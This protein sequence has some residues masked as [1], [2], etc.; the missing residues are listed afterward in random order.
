MFSTV[1]CTNEKLMQVVG[2][3]RRASWVAIDT[4]A[5]SL[6][7]YPEKL[8]L[9]QVCTEFGARLIDPLNGVPLDEL[10]AALSRHELIL[11]GGDYDL[12][13]LYKHAKFV[14]SRVFDT[15][16]AARLLGHRKFG[17]VHLLEQYLGITLE[18][19]PQKAN[20]A[21][22]P[23]TERMERYAL[24]DVQYLRPLADKLR[25][26]LGQKGRLAWLEETCARLVAECARPNSVNTDFA[27]RVKGSARLTRR[28]LAVLR[29]LWHWREKEALAASKPPY[30]ILSHELM[31]EIAATAASNPHR[32]DRLIP[33]NFSYRRRNALSKAIERGLTLPP[34][35]CPEPFQHKLNPLNDADRHRFEQ[36]KRR[37]DA[38][39]TQLGIDPALIAS[40]QLLIRLAQNWHGNVHLLMS[41]QRE[42]LT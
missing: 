14:P 19:G 21:K 31:I 3:V 25:A 17:L 42:L 1:I 11:H 41:W 16:L 23:L 24:N 27:W 6:H 13:L 8:C 38:R 36:L 35:Q 18:K 32:V 4:E 9:V 12:R 15:M 29:E 28:G 7:A 2:E 40:K 34:E 37:R 30:F 26:E 5:D 33:G 39:A 10:C 20:W 22:R